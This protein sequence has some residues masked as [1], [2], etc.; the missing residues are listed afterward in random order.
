MASEGA[1]DVGKESK[2]ISYI[3]VIFYFLYLN[4]FVE[5]MKINKVN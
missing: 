4:Y 5:N 1:V 2:E 3:S